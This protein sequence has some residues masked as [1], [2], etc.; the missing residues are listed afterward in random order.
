LLNR[1]TF[2]KLAGA[3]SLGGCASSGAAGTA[4][5]EHVLSTPSAAP[6]APTQWGVQMSPLDDT[7]VAYPL[8]S[9]LRPSWIHVGYDGRYCD[10]FV[11]LAQKLGCGVFFITDE[12]VAAIAQGAQKYASLKVAWDIL[13]EPDITLSQDALAPIDYVALAGSMIAA[14]R[15]VAPNHLTCV[16]SCSGKQ[17]SNPQWYE[18]A[19]SEGLLNTG[20]DAVG[21]HP[22]GGG[23]APDGGPP[24]TAIAEAYKALVLQDGGKQQVWNTEWGQASGMA[25][26]QTEQLLA[27]SASLAGIVPMAIWLGF[28]DS[29]TD[30]SRENSFGLVDYSYNPKP[31]FATAVKVFSS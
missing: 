31:V 21:F 6:V 17:S 16:A 2:I 11:A 24:F 30:G 27:W 18:A 29:G 3:L 5:W 4:P 26:S 10:A 1:R 15:S 13:N 22:Y 7:V 9:Q 12:N 8:L 20:A 14:I 19:F 28:R 23:A 25:Q